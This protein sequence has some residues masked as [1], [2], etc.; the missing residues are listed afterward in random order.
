MKSYIFIMLMC[1]FIFTNCFS[2]NSFYEKPLAVNYVNPLKFS[3]LWYEIARTY[4]SFEKDCVAP[5]IEYK[6]VNSSKYEITNRCFKNEIGGE[7]IVYNGTATALIE[8]NMSL[9]EKRYFWIFSKDYRVIYLDN[10]Q[11]AVISD[12]K[13]EN[14][15]IMNREPFLEKKRLNFIVSKLDKH[16][17]VSRLIYTPQDKNGRYK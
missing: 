13:M 16:M 17:D 11:T 12:E 3:G 10:Y 7:L 9:I 14:V 2:Q 5:T 1:I 8:E 4:N 15:W 6:F